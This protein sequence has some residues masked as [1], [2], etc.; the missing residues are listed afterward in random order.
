VVVRWLPFLLVVGCSYGAP[1]A[2]DTDTDVVGDDV[3]GGDSDTAVPW[4]GETDLSSFTSD[5]FPVVDD[6]IGPTALDGAWAG[7]FELDEVLPLSNKEPHCA[8]TVTMTIDGRAPRHVV[9]EFACPTWDPNL[10]ET[11]LYHPYGPVSGIGFATLDP[12]DLS[13][14]VLQ[15]ALG[16]TYMATLD[17]NRVKVQVA[18]DHLVGTFDDVKGIGTLKSGRKLTFDLA[19]AAA[20]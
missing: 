13:G 18:D 4:T 15:A 16:A 20:P 14:F 10:P 17:A 8:G 12:A 6:P 1:P 19:R 3:T 7:T 2:A 9:A 5:T 11:L